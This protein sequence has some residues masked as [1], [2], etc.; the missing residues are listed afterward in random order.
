[1]IGKLKAN[2]LREASK[3]LEF[4]PNLPT[5]CSY[6]QFTEFLKIARDPDN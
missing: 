3:T 4:K 2:Y 6:N 5:T 1:M